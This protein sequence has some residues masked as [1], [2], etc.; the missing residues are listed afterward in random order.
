MT[1]LHNQ[2]K[3]DVEEALVFLFTK[4]GRWG[5][6]PVAAGYH[7][8]DACLNKWHGEVNDFRALLI[9]SERAN[10]HVSSSIHNL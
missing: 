4:K 5:N 9:D 6:C 3:M 8:A 10:G 7:D 2:I 1:D